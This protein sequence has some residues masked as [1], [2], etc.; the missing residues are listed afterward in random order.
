M[1]II[2]LTKNWHEQKAGEQLSMDDTHADLLVQGGYA[3][4]VRQP[5]LDAMFGDLLART[6]GKL[7]EGLDSAIDAAL[8]KF[9]AENTRSKASHNPAIWGSGRDGDP[10]K[11]FAK[12]LLAVRTNDRKAIDGFGSHWVDGEAK[13]D[14][15]GQ[16]GPLG[17][18]LIPEVFI[19]RIL[20]PMQEL[21]IVEPKAFTLRS[22]TGRTFTLPA[23]DITQDPPAGGSAMFGGMV[24]TWAEEAA[25]ITQ[26][27]PLLRNIKLELHEL[28]GYVVSSNA[29]I[30]D[31]AIGLED[32]LVRLFSS[33]LAWHKDYAFL[34]GNGVGKPLG[35]LN[36]PSFLTV[37]RSGSAAFALQDAANMLARLMPGSQPSSVCWVLHPYHL[38]NLIRMLSSSTGGELVFMPNNNV[39]GAP[40]MML[41]G[42]PVF[43]TEKVPA[44]GTSGDVLLA[45]LSRYI[46]ANKVLAS[47]TAEV[48]IAYSEHVKFLTNQGAWRAVVRVDGQP[49]QKSTV[50]LADGASTVSAFVGLT[51]A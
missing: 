42:H 36:S 3:E 18:Y 8:K 25:S 29:L 38:A 2:T 51:S 26:T 5:G 33:A 23:L 31:E 19:Q 6:T 21:S 16:S 44:P 43:L 47:G 34:Q 13:A 1:A 15:T 14:L 11:S 35:I 28:S 17:G 45:D 4:Y 32:M 39:T 46:V 22:R 50:T 24:M 27:N 41:L 40:G 10:D 9:A 7:T 49:W 48:A 30:E 20:E 37:S 12:F